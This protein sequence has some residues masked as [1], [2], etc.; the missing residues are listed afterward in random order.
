MEHIDHFI[1]FSI[2][3]MNMPTIECFNT[4]V[5]MY[6]IQ[7]TFEEALEFIR[8]AETIKHLP[9]LCSFYAPIYTPLI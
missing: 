7:L 8:T 1:S 4:W 3:H 6:H 5:T 2:F 9:E